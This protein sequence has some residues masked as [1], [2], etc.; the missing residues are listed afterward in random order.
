MDFLIHAMNH[1]DIALFQQSN[2][3]DNQVTSNAF[4]LIYVFQ[5]KQ[6][7]NLFSIKGYD[8]P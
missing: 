2:T 6:K 7:V 1:N 5:K 4:L 8:N 3:I